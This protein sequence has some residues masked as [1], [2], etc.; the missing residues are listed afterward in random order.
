MHALKFQ[1]HKVIPVN[2][3][4][5]PPLSTTN[6]TLQYLRRAASEESKRQSAK[7]GKAR[8]SSANTTTGVSGKLSAARPIKTSLAITIM[9][10]P[11][12]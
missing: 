2:V 1:N 5:L 7:L 12:V 9:Y 3:A 10:P 4:H 11:T 8:H 6:H